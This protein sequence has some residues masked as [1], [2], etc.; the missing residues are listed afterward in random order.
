VEREFTSRKMW[1]KALKLQEKRIRAGKVKVPTTKL[2]K[3]L[4][5]M[6]KKNVVPIFNRKNTVVTQKEILSIVRALKQARKVSKGLLIKAPR[7]VRSTRGGRS[8][9]Y[10]KDLSSGV[11]R[12]FTSRKMWIKALKLQEKRIRAGKVKVPTT[13]LAKWLNIMNKKNVV[14]IFNRKNTV[15][16]QKEILSIVRALKQARKVSKGLLIKAPRGVRSTR[17]GRSI[18]YFKDL[19]SGV[20]RE[21]TSRKMWIKALKLQEK[22]IRAG[23]VKVPTTKLAK[24]LNIMNKKNVVPIFN[25]KNTVVT[26]KE[27]LSIVRALKQARKV[28]K[29]L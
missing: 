18:Y 11:E 14:P 8:I 29:G 21:F 1:I 17:G 6:N 10:F 22:R 26:Q 15:V 27:I 16:T 9:Y 4:N 25:R 20:E 24:W 19:S 2:A 5:I 13:K 12:E 28:S 3:W 23:K 7:G